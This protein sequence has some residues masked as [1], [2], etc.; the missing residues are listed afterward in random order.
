MMG[1]D[2]DSVHLAQEREKWESVLNSV[3]ILRVP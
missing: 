2:V 3:M 1:G